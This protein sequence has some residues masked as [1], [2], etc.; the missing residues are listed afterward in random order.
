MNAENRYFRSQNS[1]N[2]LKDA[3]CQNCPMTMPFYH[4]APAFREISFPL[5][6]S[7][8]R[9]IL[10]SVIIVVIFV[11]EEVNICK[12]IEPRHYL[13]EKQKQFSKFDICLP[14]IFVLCF[15]ISLWIRIATAW[16]RHRLRGNENFAANPKTIT[17]ESR[18]GRPSRFRWNF[19]AW[20]GQS[21]RR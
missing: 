1:S 13:R 12:E 7:K 15:G 16:G 19:R 21:I 3:F 5:F 18:N 9:R 4:A 2:F 20:R 11:V 10:T 14:A 17:N 8:N 6:S